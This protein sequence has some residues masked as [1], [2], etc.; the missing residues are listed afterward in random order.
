MLLGLDDEI[1]FGKYGGYTVREV[2][3]KNPGYL[4]WCIENLDGIKFSEDVEAEL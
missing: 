1:T 3:D 4:R 2:L